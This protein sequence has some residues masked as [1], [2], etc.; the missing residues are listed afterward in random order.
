MRIL[1]ADDHDLLRDTLVLYLEGAG[2]FE[3]SAAPDLPTALDLIASGQSFDVVLLDLNM[4][5]MNGL[6]GL[7]QALDAGDGTHV[8]LM[9]GVA[10]REVAAE[11]LE[12]GA[13]GFLPKSLPASLTLWPRQP[14]LPL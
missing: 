8:A 13:A 4:P 11:A 6:E 3:T 7:R 5:G 9:S 1:I 2:G 12:M 14:F 10:S